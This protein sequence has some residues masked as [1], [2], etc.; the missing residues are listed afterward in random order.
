[1]PNSTRGHRRRQLTIVVTKPT[2]NMDIICIFLLIDIE[3][4]ANVGRDKVRMEKSRRIC[5]PPLR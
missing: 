5:E 1:M 2:A 3:T 4:F